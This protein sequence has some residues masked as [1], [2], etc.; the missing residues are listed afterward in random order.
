MAAVRAGRKL[1]RFLLEAPNLGPAQGIGLDA[2]IGDR[3]HESRL[4][5]AEFPLE[6]TRPQRYVSGVAAWVLMRVDGGY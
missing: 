4:G 1:G 2:F 3:E 6:R 5:A